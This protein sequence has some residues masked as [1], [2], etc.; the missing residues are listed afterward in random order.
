MFKFHSEILASINFNKYKILSPGLENNKTF[1]G[2]F[3]LFT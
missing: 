1:Q 2:N 3:F